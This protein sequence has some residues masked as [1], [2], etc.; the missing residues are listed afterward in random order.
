MKVEEVIN[1]IRS[2]EELVK[3]EIIK[4]DKFFMYKLLDLMRRNKTLMINAAFIHKS[5]ST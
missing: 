1:C 2:F 5:L 4:I 3:N